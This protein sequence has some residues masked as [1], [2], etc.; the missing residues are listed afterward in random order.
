MALP[1]GDAKAERFAEESMICHIQ[2]SQE[3]ILAT[4]DLPSIENDTMALLQQILSKLSKKFL[5]SSDLSACMLP[6]TSS[7][8]KGR[9]LLVLLHH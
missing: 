9:R 1:I 7:L 2:L 6:F 3:E 8:S 4:A 5:L